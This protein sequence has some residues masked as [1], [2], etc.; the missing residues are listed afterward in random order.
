MT[1]KNMN[2]IIPDVKTFEAGELNTTSILER[3]QGFRIATEAGFVSS[4]ELLQLTVL[5]TAQHRNTQMAEVPYTVSV[6]FA[7]DP[8]CQILL[9]LW[10]LGHS[11]FLPCLGGRSFL[12]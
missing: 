3:S 2:K 12:F 8:L 11:F 5:A 7:L 6:F 9:L 10:F 4:S 1:F